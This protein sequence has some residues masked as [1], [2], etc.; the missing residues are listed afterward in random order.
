LVG[1]GSRSRA[2]TLWYTLYFSKGLYQEGETVARFADGPAAL[3]RDAGIVQIFRTGGKGEEAARGFRVTWAKLGRDGLQD[4]PLASGETVSAEIGSLLQAGGKGGV[5]ILWLEGDELISALRALDGASGGPKM[6]FA[7]AT[8]L[9]WDYAVV[10]EQL[11]GRVYLSYPYGLPEDGTKRLLVL[12][13]WLRARKIPATDELIQGKMYF[14]GWM[15]PGAI[16]ELRSELYRDYFLE[17]FE[18]MPDQDYAIPVYPRLS[19]GPGQRYAAKGCYIMRLSPGD[20][21]HL[22]KASGWVVN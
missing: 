20:D 17:A 9:D 11:R 1:L 3:P 22:V 10:P 18:M 8:L 7:S 12:K 2:S 21:P 6:V 14:L 15:L 13:A 4:R 16:K 5:L 19:F